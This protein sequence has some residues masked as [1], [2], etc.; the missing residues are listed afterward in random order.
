MTRTERATSS[1]IVA[2]EVARDIPAGAYAGLAWRAIEGAIH[3]EVSAAEPV[4]G[5]D[6]LAAGRAGVP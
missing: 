5:L 3:G 6:A 2:V 1:A 4:A